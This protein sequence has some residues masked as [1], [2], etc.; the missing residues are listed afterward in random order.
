[1]LGRG[2]GRRR[3][4]EEEG[5][6]KVERR[7]S[8]R[9]WKLHEHVKPQIIN[10]KPKTPKPK[11]QTPNPKHKTLT[12]SSHKPLHWSLEGEWEGEGGA[13]DVSAASSEG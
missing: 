11:P 13:D 8:M 1:M 4:E 3:Q 5:V 10:S 6:G 7:A 2:G 9:S 12:W